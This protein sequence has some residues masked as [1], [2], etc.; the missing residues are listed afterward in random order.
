MMARSRRRSCSSSERPSSSPRTTR[1]AARSRVAGSIQWSGPS[2]AGRGGRGNAAARPPDG[3]APR[4]T[5]PG[6]V[7]GVVLDVPGQHDRLGGTPALVSDSTA[8]SR[9][10]GGRLRRGGRPTPRGPGVIGREYDAQ[11]IGPPR[12]TEPVDRTPPT[13]PHL[14]RTGRAISPCPGR[15]RPP[16]VSEQAAVADAAEL[17][18]V[19]GELDHLLRR[20]VEGGVTITDSTS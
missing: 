8:S 10:R 9:L 6:Q 3:R 12:G 18:A 19:G 20:H 1:C 17:V 2:P 7:L 14:R 15:R 4:R 11:G 5:H 16:G 13:V